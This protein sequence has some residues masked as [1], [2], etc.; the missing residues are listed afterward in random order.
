L[1]PLPPTCP[2]PNDMLTSDTI[3]FDGSSFI[4]PSSYVTLYQ[5]LFE[6][7]IQEFQEKC[8]TDDDQNLVLS[9]YYDSPHLFQVYNGRWFSLFKELQSLP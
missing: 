5:D 2:D 8:I 4:V 6:Q 3:Y 9:I 7:K 1:T